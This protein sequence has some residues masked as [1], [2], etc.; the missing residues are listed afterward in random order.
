MN[1]FWVLVLTVA[2]IAEEIFPW[3]L[4]MSKALGGMLLAAAAYLA[5]RRLFFPHGERHGQPRHGLYGRR[6]TRRIPEIRTRRP[7]Q[8]LAEPLPRREG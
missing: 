4:L 5:I 2:V 3:G 8:G 7:S 1:L 6:L